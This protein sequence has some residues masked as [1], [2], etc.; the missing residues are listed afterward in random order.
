MGTFGL[1]LAG[2]DLDKHQ[3]R[4]LW[5]KVDRDDSNSI[6]FS[7]F[8]A[9]MFDLKAQRAPIKNERLKLKAKPSNKTKYS[10]LNLQD[11]KVAPGDDDGD[12]DMYNESINHQKSLKVRSDSPDDFEFDNEE[13]REEGDTPDRGENDAE[14]NKILQNI[15][16]QIDR[17]EKQKDEVLGGFPIWQNPTA[18][19]FDWHGEYHG[20]FSGSRPGTNGNMGFPSPSSPLMGNSRP[21]SGFS[22]STGKPMMPVGV[23]P[24]FMPSPFSMPY[25]GAAAPFNFDPYT[26]K[27]VTPDQMQG[28][29]MPGMIMNP[30]IMP[31]AMYPGVH[32]QQ[33]PYFSNPSPPSS[34]SATLDERAHALASNLTPV[35]GRDRKR[36][37]KN[38][39]KDDKTLKSTLC[40]V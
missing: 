36:P 32:P 3:F 22:G 26:G 23:T 16:S 17:L 1:K 19:Q 35:A 10:M 4:K 39:Q 33:M 5:R 40:S 14:F 13:T 27:P 34:N 24:G 25:G 38:E 8:L 11:N 12:D 6:D 2:N 37:V 21:G 9:F 30:Y 31:G 20:G 29:M 7:E 18:G 28:M 15:R